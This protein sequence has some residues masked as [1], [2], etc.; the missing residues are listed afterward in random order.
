MFADDTTLYIAGYSVADISA[1]L[2]CALASAYKWLSDSSLQLNTTKTKCMLIHSCHRRS[3]L[4]LDVQL[5]DTPIE[6]VQSYKYLGVVNSDT[7]SWAEHI[8]LVGSTAAKGISKL[9]W[10]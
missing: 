7:L 10:I 1:K 4:S 3:R 5:N 6:Q 9:S 8:D 2:S